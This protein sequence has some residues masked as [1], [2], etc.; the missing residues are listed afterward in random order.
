MRDDLG[1][2]EEGERVEVR[3]VTGTLERVGQRQAFVRLTGPVPG[4]L[5]VFLHD[6]G[7]G[8][9]TAGLRA[10]LF[11]A[12]APAFVRRGQP[13]WQAWLRGLSVEAR[14]A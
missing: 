14:T 13:A 9:A 2:S 12:E 6:M 7:E 8:Q 3:G 1:L 10:Y 11:C 4:M 5:N